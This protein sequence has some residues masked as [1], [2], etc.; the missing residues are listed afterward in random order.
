M[1]S[2]VKQLERSSD[3][4]EKRDFREIVEGELTPSAASKGKFP[5]L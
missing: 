3:Q 2:T 4:N 1:K 5:E